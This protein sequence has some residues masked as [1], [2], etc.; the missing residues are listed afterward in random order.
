M[1]YINAIQLSTSRILN[2]TEIN[3]YIAVLQNNLTRLLD[4]DTPRPVERDGLLSI[5]S[6]LTVFPKEPHER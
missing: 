2:K 6:T 4:S 3:G 1:L 5:D